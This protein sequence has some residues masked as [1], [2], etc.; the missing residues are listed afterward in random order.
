ME[1]KF[2]PKEKVWMMYGNKPTCAPITEI[3]LNNKVEYYFWHQDFLFTDKSICY[4]N[5]FRVDE[6]LLYKT[7]EA[8]I[9]AL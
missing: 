9:S 8:L 5:T 7:K 6:G 4:D 2:Q 1:L 3:R